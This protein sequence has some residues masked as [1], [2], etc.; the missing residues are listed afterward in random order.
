MP[1]FTV[2][3]LKEIARALREKGYD[4]LANIITWWDFR[5]TYEMKSAEYI[6]MRRPLKEMPLFIKDESEGIRTI[7]IMRLKIGK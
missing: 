5:G 1:R 3:E 7:A 6:V 2:L 4:G